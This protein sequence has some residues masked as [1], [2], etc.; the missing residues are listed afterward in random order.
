[1]ARHIHL[2]HPGH[3]A[4]LFVTALGLG[5]IG[6]Y[7]C[8]PQSGRRRRDQARDR[9]RELMAEAR[10]LLIEHQPKGS[11][12][13]VVRKTLHINAPVAEVYHHWSVEN[14]PQWMSHVKE[15][16]PL[17]D[18]R[19]HWV[20]DG[21]G[22]VPVEWISEITSAVENRELAW[23]SVEG[24]TID[25]AGHVD[26]TEEK[27]GTK[28]QVTLCYMPPMGHIGDFVARALGADPGSRMDDDLARFKALIET[29]AQ[30]TAAQQPV[31]GAP[32]WPSSDAR[33]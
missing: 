13:I 11:R 14:F 8:D 28:V 20:V 32:P 22:G 4:A 1:M 21:P 31:S 2:H 23:R 9:A 5:A 33:H 30:D 27:G 26:F 16:R 19:Y 10:R 15:V 6:M 25:N 24:S 18:G 29:P 7:L 12:G 17:E 3:D